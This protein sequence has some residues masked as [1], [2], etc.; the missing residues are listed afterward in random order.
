[1]RRHY[2]GRFRRR[3]IH[4][5][6]LRP[7]SSRM[8][9]LTHQLLGYLRLLRRGKP[10]GNRAYWLCRWE[11]RYR[12]Q[13]CG[14]VKGVR[15][16]ALR[17][18]WRNQILQRAY[19]NAQRHHHLAVS[20]SQARQSSGSGASRRDRVY[21]CLGDCGKRVKV[22]GRFLRGGRTRSCGCD[23]RATR[24]TTTKHGQ[25]RIACKTSTY[26][27]YHRQKSLCRLRCAQ[28]KY[29][30]DRGVRFRFESCGDFYADGRN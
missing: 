30:R 23:Y 6:F 19:S 20:V 14:F 17:G 24:T 16:D 1:M 29:V 15:S 22:Q 7:P 21:S 27:A 28:A 18:E 9:N 12:G 8:Q 5:A 10:R 26:N 4:P 11:A 13:V 3:A 2:R 25:S